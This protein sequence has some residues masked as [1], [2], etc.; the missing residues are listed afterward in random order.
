MI[1]AIRPTATIPDSLKMAWWARKCLVQ[2]MLVHPFLSLHCLPALPRC[3]ARSAKPLSEHT[4]RHLPF[5]EFQ[6][7]CRSID[8]EWS[9][10]D[11]NQHSAR[12]LR[13]RLSPKAQPWDSGNTGQEKRQACLPA[14]PVAGLPPSLKR[15]GALIPSRDFLPS[16]ESCLL[17]LCLSHLP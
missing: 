14:V 16:C 9:H 4:R 5:F 10:T 3:H 6:P 1:W 17:F 8:S 13:H 12:N 11:I 7:L 2:S 15:V